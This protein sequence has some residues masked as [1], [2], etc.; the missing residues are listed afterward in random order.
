MFLLIVIVDLTKRVTNVLT[1]YSIFVMSYLYCDV[2]YFS[3]TQII[4]RTL[5]LLCDCHCV[6][7]VTAE[8]HLNAVN[9]TQ[10]E[11]D[12]ILV[13]YDSEY[14]WLLDFVVAVAQ[15][16]LNS[17]CNNNWNGIL[18]IFPE[19]R[20]YLFRITTFQNHPRFVVNT[21]TKISWNY[22]SPNIDMLNFFILL[23]S[24]RVTF[25]SIYKKSSTLNFL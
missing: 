17:I 7:Y 13:C 11:R 23:P 16:C 21:N 14:Y 24:L 3:F 10:L 6:W 8:K 20:K 12:S 19:Q 25:I 4:N 22:F 5:D 2:V 1:I 9:V 18:D 15:I